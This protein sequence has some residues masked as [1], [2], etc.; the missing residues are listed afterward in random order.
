[1]LYTISENFEPGIRR[2]PIG[3]GS[4]DF[5]PRDSDSSYNRL[6]ELWRY[7]C[8]V[9]KGLTNIILVSYSR[10]HIINFS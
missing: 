9:R 8:S 1:M 2:G 4:V 7:V 3:S 6:Y 5:Y 10:F